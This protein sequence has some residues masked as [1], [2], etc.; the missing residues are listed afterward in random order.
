MASCLL[1]I[2]GE[3]LVQISYTRSGTDYVIQTFGG[4]LY[5]EDTDTNVFFTK[6][7]GNIS[8]SS[9]C[10]TLV[11]KPLVCYLIKWSNLNI[12]NYTFKNLIY[13]N[14]IIALPENLNF[15]NSYKE[16]FES[17]NSLSLPYKVIGYK[18]NNSINSDS[19][20]GG[21]FSEYLNV[22]ILFRSFL[23]NIPEI[24]ISNGNNSFFIKGQPYNC[25]T[26]GFIEINI[27]ENE[28]LN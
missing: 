20:S 19:V 4:N 8:V 22:D 13:N 6:L 27:C 11:E 9:S 2:T 3:G 17:I 14:S 5:I 26:I 7:Y 15:P 25:D 23:E 12:K 1:N 16:V 10:L 18:I 24:E 28:F 21:G